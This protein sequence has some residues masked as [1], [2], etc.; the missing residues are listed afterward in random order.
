MI[1]LCVVLAL[2]IIAF[3]AVLLLD[4]VPCAFRWYERIGIGSLSKEATAENVLNLL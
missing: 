4:A 3:I 1:A 2:I